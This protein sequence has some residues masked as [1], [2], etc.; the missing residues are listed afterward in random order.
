[1]LNLTPTE[2]AIV[3]EI[4]TTLADDCDVWMFGSRANGT[5]KPFSDLDLC[6][7]AKNGESLTL[8]QLALLEEAFSESHLPFKVDVVDWYT[9]SELFKLAIEPKLI[10]FTK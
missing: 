2:F 7:K 3:K 6:L 4:L 10:D 9:L 8:Q 1:M 5:P